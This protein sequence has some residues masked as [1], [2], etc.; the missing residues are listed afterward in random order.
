MIDMG[1]QHCMLEG[2]SWETYERLL[3]DL[4]DRKIFLTYDRGTLEIMSPSLPHGTDEALIV[5]L[6]T[7]YADEADIP[8]RSCGMVTIKRKDLA[9]GLEPDQCFYV[10]NER[11]VATSRLVDFKVYPPDLAIEIEISRRLSKRKEIY[12]ALG[13]PE[14]WLDDGQSFRVLQLRKDGSYKLVRRSL[15][16]PELDLSEFERFLRMWPDKSEY[17]LVREFRAWLRALKR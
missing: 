3:H 14:I 10:K 4:N 16:F 15:N 7:A 1:E 17:E 8:I 12:A 11:F 5:R 9:R 13:V 2:V 6:L